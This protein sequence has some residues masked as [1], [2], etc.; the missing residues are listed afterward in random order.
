MARQRR[1]LSVSVVVDASVAAKWVVPEA[2]S[3]RAEEV[4]V[5]EEALIA[6]TLILAEIGNAVWKRAIRGAMTQADAIEAIETATGLFAA[7]IPIEQLAGRA[8]E[9]AVAFRHPIYDCFYLAL[10][11]RENAA[12]VTADE[13][14]FA[15]ARKARIKVRRL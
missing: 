9:I 11:Q 13:R 7:L 14:L 15:A 5:S 1:A 10:A 12:I 3:Q 4:R 6:R 8:V 2:E